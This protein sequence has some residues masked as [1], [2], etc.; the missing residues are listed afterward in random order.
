[1]PGLPIASWVIDIP[2]CSLRSQLSFTYRE[3]LRTAPSILAKESWKDGRGGRDYPG[4][5]VINGSPTQEPSPT[6]QLFPLGLGEPATVIHGS[7][8]RGSSA[9][10]TAAALCSSCPALGSVSPGECKVMSAEVTPSSLVHSPLCRADATT[11]SMILR[12]LSNAVAP[13][14]CKPGPR[15]R[16]WSLTLWSSLSACKTFDATAVVI[17]VIPRLQSHPVIAGS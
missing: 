16:S 3:Y 5:L 1:M 7:P 2:K 12:R 6:V 10:T 4:D 14:V 15:P 8:R 13:S 9:A 17:G 11:T